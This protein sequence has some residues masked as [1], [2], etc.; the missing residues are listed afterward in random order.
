MEIFASKGAPPVSMTP[1]ANFATY[2]ASVIDTGGKIWKQYQT[3]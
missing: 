1:G 2:F 3:P